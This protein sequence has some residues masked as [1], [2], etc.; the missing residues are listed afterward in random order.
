MA[1]RLN[2]ENIQPMHLSLHHLVA[3]APWCHE[4]LLEEVRQYLLPNMLEHAPVVAW[5]VDDTGYQ[6]RPAFGRGRPSILRTSRQARKLPSRSEPVGGDLEFESA[7]RISAVF[8]EGMG[9]RRRASGE[10][11]GGRGDCLS[12]QAGN[13]CRADPRS[14]GGWGDSRA[15]LAD[16]AYGNDSELRGV[17]NELELQYL[18]GVQSSMTVWEPG[19][20]PLPA[21]PRGKM[22]LPPRLLQRSRNH[23]PVSVKQLAMSLLSAAFREITW[24]EGTA[25]KLRSRFAGVC[26]CAAHGDYAEE[27]LLIEWPR[28]EKE[29][30]KYWLSTLPLHTRLKALVKIARH[31][32]II[33][34]DY[35]ELKQELGLGHFEGRNWRGFHHPR[36]AGS[37]W[38]RSEPSFPLCPR[39]RLVLARL[40]LRQWPHCPFCSSPPS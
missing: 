12:D 31:R 14:G 16:T 38:P 20:Q 15:V 22:G 35:R 17:L 39:I 24:R 36:H 11:R 4:V 19:K 21:K 3:K 32:W 26:V 23:H 27:W 7:D 18:M 37:Y 30:T 25:H 33:E 29:L 1:V 9:A 34:L 40:I 6:E 8:A 13:R 5:I 28:G 2:P 10:S